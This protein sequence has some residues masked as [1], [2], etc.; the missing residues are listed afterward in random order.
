M[1]CRI[2]VSPIMRVLKYLPHPS[3]V[4]I[5][6]QIHNSSDLVI[7]TNILVAHCEQITRLDA[8][9]IYASDR[10]L[11]KIVDPHVG[12]PS[13]AHNCHRDMNYTLLGKLMEHKFQRGNLCAP[14]VTN[15]KKKKK[16]KNNIYIYILNFVRG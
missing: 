7:R 15:P 1:T 13:T 3:K 14:V 8:V 12:D 6:S 2:V 16:V 10:D 11:K 9:N 4:Q 5:N